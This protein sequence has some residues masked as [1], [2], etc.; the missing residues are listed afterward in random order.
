[1][2]GLISDEY[3][4][5]WSQNGVMALFVLTVHSDALEEQLDLATDFIARIVHG[6][7]PIVVAEQLN[8]GHVVLMMVVVIVLVP[9]KELSDAVVILSQGDGTTEW[10]ALPKHSFYL[11][12]PLRAVLGAYAAGAGRRFPIRLFAVDEGFVFALPGAHLDA[13]ARRR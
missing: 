8:F 11:G 4:N 9:G 7:A 13:A 3:E 10:V 6:Y 12:V 2:S 1:L 5:D